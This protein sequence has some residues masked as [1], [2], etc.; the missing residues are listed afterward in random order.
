MFYTAYLRFDV[1][2]LAGRTV[3]SAKL[4]LFSTDG[5]PNGGS[6]YKMP[7]N[8]TETGIT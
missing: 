3:T 2:G 6:L 5:G 8:W 1:S 4:R 7:T